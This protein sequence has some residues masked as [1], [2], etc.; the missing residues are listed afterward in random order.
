M[1]MGFPAFICGRYLRDMG[2]RDKK[3]HSKHNMRGCL[4]QTRM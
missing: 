1:E 2:E 4:N 3:L